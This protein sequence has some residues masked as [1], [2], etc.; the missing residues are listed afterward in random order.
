MFNKGK[1][2][3]FLKQAKEMKKAL[4]KHKSE[5]SKLYFEGS[6]FGRK[7]NVKVDGNQKVLKIEIDPSLDFTIISKIENSIVDA[8]NDALKKANK[9]SEK[10]MSKLSGGM[11]GGLGDGFKIPGLN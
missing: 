1:I 8:T 10:R 2:G 6:S 7:I 3:D 5:L 11:L 9:E 4:D